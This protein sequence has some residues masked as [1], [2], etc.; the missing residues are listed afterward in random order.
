MHGQVFVKKKKAGSLFSKKIDVGQDGL[1][2]EVVNSYATPTTSLSAVRSEVRFLHAAFSSACDQFVAGDCQGSIYLF[3]L[4]RNRFALL[5]RLSVPCTCLAFALRR[6]SEFLV[7]LADCTLRCYSV[8]SPDGVA[9]MRGH[10]S[11]IVAISVHSSGRYAISTS[12]DAAVLWNLD[13]FERKRSLDLGGGSR[14]AVGVGLLRAFFVPRSDTILTCFKDGSVHA[15]SSETMERQFELT[16]TLA[17]DVCYRTFACNA[18]GCRLAAAGRSNVVHI[19]CLETRTLEKALEL[20]SDERGVRQLRYAPTHLHASD[21][22]A[23]VCSSGLA[24]FVD[25]K[26]SCELFNVGS[27]EL[28]V[29]SLDMA[30]MASAPAASGSVKCACVMDSGNVAVYDVGLLAQQQREAAAADA[31]AAAGSGGR[32]SAAVADRPAVQTVRVRVRPGD[33][34]KELI[35]QRVE[36]SRTLNGEKLRHILREYGEFPER[37]RCFIW[38]T[39]L[40]LPENFEAYDVLVAK[41]VHPAYVNVHRVYPIRSQKLLRV[42]QRLLSALAYWAPVA[43]ET[44]FLPLL[45]FPFAKLLQNNQLLAFEVSATV[46]TSWC[47]RWFDYAPHPP[48]NVLSAVENVLS[49]HDKELFQHFVKHGVTAQ[50]YAWSL[51]E[52]GFSEVFTRAEWLRLWDHLVVSPPAFLPIAAVAYSLAA[53]VPLLGC[54]DTDEFRQFYRHHNATGVARVLDEAYRLMETTPDD[55]HPRGLMEPFRPLNAGG[56]YPLAAKF[57]HRVKDYPQQE[58]ERI[59]KEELE[60][61]RTDGVVTWDK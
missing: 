28:R 18:S 43:T 14:G 1:Y 7:A 21:V 9:V 12:A 24:R 50:L 51:L 39:V 15:W 56:Q 25:V 27:R 37:Y 57:P 11:S 41:G 10:D 47:Q 16:S 4:V 3:D 61:L 45:V 54:R 32:S 44:T 35:A 53:R 19:W 23:M 49:Y 60:F 6:K 31:A 46:L 22:L 13:T 17:S 5:L 30:V 26:T 42:F 20:P 58:K 40:R 55:I 36:Q 59:R 2:L 48:V 52:T 38:K 29:T 34:V 33:R 8:D